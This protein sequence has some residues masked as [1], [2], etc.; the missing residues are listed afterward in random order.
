MTIQCPAGELLPGVAGMTTEVPQRIPFPTGNQEARGVYG[1]LTNGQRL[2]GHLPRAI[3]EGS[4]AFS[5]SLL[6][7]G[8][9]PPSLR[10]MIIVRVGYHTNSVYEVEQHRSLAMKFDVEERK[11]DALACKPAPDLSEAESA[12]IAFVD[13][14]ITVNRPSDSVL[15]RV[16]S[17]FDDGELLEM[18]FVAGNWWTLSRMLETA[19]IP[20]EERRI[21]DETG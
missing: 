18:I 8:R 4:R 16:R 17:Y 21:G 10:E 14:L 20:L 1:R 12:V 9:L 11:L 15:D 3:Q 7:D 13:E 2:A 5:A 19:G 6:R